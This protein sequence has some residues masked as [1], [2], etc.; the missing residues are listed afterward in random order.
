MTRRLI[1]WTLTL[2]LLI[3]AALP[4]QAS[5]TSLD[6][7]LSRWLADQTAVNLTATLQVNTL[8][9]F[10]ETTIGLLNGVLKH[11]QIDATL[12]QS[13]EES[14]TAFSIRMN[15]QTLMDLAEHQAGDTYTLTTS[16]LPNRTLV[17]T[18][19]AAIDRLLGTQ[20]VAETS[21]AT[22][23]DPPAGAEDHAD[24]AADAPTGTE[25]VTAPATD[26]PADAATVPPA[27]TTT[28]TPESTVA[29]AQTLTENQP[30]DAAEA[31]NMLD[32]VAQLQTCYQALT[33]GIKDFAT[34]KR[35]NYNIKG[36]GAGKW[37]RI[38]RL[39]DEQSASLLSPLRA[40]LACGMDEAYQ[41]EL[42]QATFAKGFIVALYQNEAN[43]DICVYLKGNLVYPDGDQRRLVWQWAFTTNGLKRK[44][45]FKYEVSRLKGATDS[46]LI[47]ASCTQES[48]SDL[49]TIDG[50][51]ETTLK[52][53][54]TTD[55]GTARVE[56]NGKRDENSALTCQGNISQELARTSGE[57]TVKT[58]EKMS[59]DL[60]FTPGAEGSVL[61][62][63]LGYSTLNGKVTQTDLL[64]T[65]GT[66][67]TASD[68]AAQTAES[69]NGEAGT[70]T[71]ATDETAE[72]EAT[73]TANV[74][75]QISSI[76]QLDEEPTDAT[77][78]AEA[79]ES[80]DA[81]LVGALP[82]GVQT[83]KTPAEAT[84]IQLDAMD[85]NAVETLLAEAAQNFAGSLLLAVAALPTEDSGL[86]ADGMTEEDYT[87]FLALLGAM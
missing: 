53:G 77:A 6:A 20:A 34:E 62:G 23:S 66:D 26:T 29:D 7:A 40:V 85:A 5:V 49:F 12:T 78:A 58:T 83:Y 74:D 76:E 43:Q 86:L 42:A 82:I 32:A 65:L 13:G 4:A 79:Q 10:D 9:P 72:P 87:A 70:E 2:M 63:T 35:A 75:T 18:E 25:G 50:K 61:S 52:R 67:A 71:V 39:T 59:V 81:Y 60:L 80:T 17:S 51:T 57:D 16:L 3:G 38:A 33:D 44:D 37:S 64:F 55:K 46:R 8:M 28:P 68:S 22:A 14:D 47:S 56:L 31:F 54:K 24:T 45:I 73:P 84:S 30:S 11:T 69:Q 15:G 48:R 27:D 21:T 19:T 41:A 36:I 1:A